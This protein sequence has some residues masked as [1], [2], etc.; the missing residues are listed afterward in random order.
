MNYFCQR[1]SITEKDVKIIFS[2]ILKVNVF[3]RPLLESNCMHGSISIE[4]ISFSRKCDIK[5]T[6][7]KSVT[8]TSI[9]VMFISKNSNTLAWRSGGVMDCHATARVRFPVGPVYLSS[10]ASFSRDSKCGCRL[11]MTLLSMGRKHNQ[12]QPQ[13]FCFNKTAS[14]LIRDK[15]TK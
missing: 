14:Q 11:R 8:D 10:F 2:E 6:N 4:N 15:Y 1:Y 12:S 9:W 13:A 5:T 7:A 3:T